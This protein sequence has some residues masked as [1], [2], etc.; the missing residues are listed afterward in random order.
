MNFTGVIRT[1]NSIN[2]LVNVNP[3]ESGWQSCLLKIHLSEIASFH[4][5]NDADRREGELTEELNGISTGTSTGISDKPLNLLITEHAFKL[6][7][8]ST[9]KVW[10]AS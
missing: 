8:S 2:L 5:L 10:V 3:L 9:L 7:F 4:L 1:M 6:D